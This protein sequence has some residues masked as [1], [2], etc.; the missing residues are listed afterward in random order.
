M[1]LT[2]VADFGFASNKRAAPAI[3]GMSHGQDDVRALMARILAE[4]ETAPD[5]L[6]TAGDADDDDD[7][8]ARL[9]PLVRTLAEGEALLARVSVPQ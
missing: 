4:M 7:A 5:A 1:L 8:R 2:R 9:A 6:R 3:T